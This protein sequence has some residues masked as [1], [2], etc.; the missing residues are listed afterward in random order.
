MSASS[1]LGKCSCR[2]STNVFNQV[3]RQRSLRCLADVAITLVVARRQF[4]LSRTG[5]RHRVRPAKVRESP[6]RKL[7]LFGDIVARCRDSTT[8]FSVGGTV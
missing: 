8:D 4:L 3:H 6:V 2:D 5:G 7:F 1:V